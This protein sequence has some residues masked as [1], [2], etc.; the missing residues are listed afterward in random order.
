MTITLKYALPYPLHIAQWG[1]DV[2]GGSFGIIKQYAARCL[3]NIEPYCRNLQSW[4]RAIARYPADSVCY[5]NSLFTSKTGIS[6]STYGIN[7]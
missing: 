3:Q 1:H 2:W 5:P 7:G 6:S 4:Q